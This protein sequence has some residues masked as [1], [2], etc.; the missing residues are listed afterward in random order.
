[1]KYYN[2]NEEILAKYLTEEEYEIVIYFGDS[3]VKNL[4]SREH[5]IPDGNT[6]TLREVN[7]YMLNR[8]GEEILDLRYSSY[9]IYEDIVPSHP[10]I[11]DYIKDWINKSTIQD[12]Y[13]AWK[14]AKNAIENLDNVL[15]KNKMPKSTYYLLNSRLNYT[16]YENGE[17]NEF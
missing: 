11:V 12:S 5:I 8:F 6:K 15:K 14:K 13:K 9:H 16:S 2:T 3:R 1:M 17:Y 7:E 4:L 10:L